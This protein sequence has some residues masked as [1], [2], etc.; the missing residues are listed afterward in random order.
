MAF[1]SAGREVGDATIKLIMSS[2]TQNITENLGYVPYAE[3][4]LAG[5]M[6]DTLTSAALT[7]IANFAVGVSTLTTNSFIDA[8]AIY[9]ISI[10]GEE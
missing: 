10:W 4:N 5:P 7:D 9:K 6:S 3:A 2:T 8:Q 1:T